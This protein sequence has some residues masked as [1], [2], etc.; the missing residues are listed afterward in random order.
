[1]ASDLL[2]T[3]RV[4]LSKISD[5]EH[6]PSEV[7][8]ALNTWLRDSGESIKV[9]IE[10]EVER[11]VKKMGFV[12]QADFD[13]LVKEVELL[14]NPAAPKRSKAT[15]DKSKSS[16]GASVKKTA[17]VGAPKSV[18]KKVVAAKSAP[19]KTTAAKAKK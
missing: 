1:M 11:S 16:T 6:N 9:K 7:V 5:G 4:Y 12:K 17:K 14:R 3:L 18:S 2:S 10:E 13:R 15:S 8:S 19:K